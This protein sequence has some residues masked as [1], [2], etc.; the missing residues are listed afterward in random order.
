MATL[1]ELK[2]ANTEEEELLAAEAL[3]AAGE[4]EEIDLEKEEEEAFEL[5][6]EGEVK[7]DEDGNPI[8]KAV[9]TPEWMQEGGEAPDTGMMPVS[10][11]VKTKHKFQGR[12]EVKDGEI[13][14]L[15]AENLRL[16]QGGGRQQTGARC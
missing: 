3:A 13:E 7:L 15:K 6:A 16:Q 4:E 9:D 14:R 8:P 12:L 5:D 10:A 1:E 11:H 2:A